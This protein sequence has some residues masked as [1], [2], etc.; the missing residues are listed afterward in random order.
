[1][2]HMSND[3]HQSKKLE[4]ELKLNEGKVFIH[5]LSQYTDVFFQKKWF[6]IVKELFN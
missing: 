5:S 6:D 2:I 4:F 3:K 1:M